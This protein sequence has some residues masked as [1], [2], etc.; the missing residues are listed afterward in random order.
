MTPED[1]A[2]GIDIVGPSNLMTLVRSI[3]AYWKPMLDMMRVMIGISA[4]FRI[5]L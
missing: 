3:P 5:S 2:C 4:F 1:F